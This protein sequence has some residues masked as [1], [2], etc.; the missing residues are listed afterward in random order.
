[1][2]SPVLFS[3]T[4][5]VALALAASALAFV[6]G[7]TAADPA[8]EY[9]RGV[10]AG[11]RLGR[12][13][14]RAALAEG[15]EHYER[16]FARGRAA[17]VAEGRR[18]GRAAGLRRGRALGRQDAFG[19]FPGGW[20]VDRWYVVSVTRGDDGARYGVGARVR[21]EPGQWY[22]LCDGGRARDRICQRL[23]EGAGARPSGSRRTVSR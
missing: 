3:V 2:R 18:S 4:L 20:Q 12:Q 19:S 8:G 7:R 10:A 11:E 1:V 6:G 13:E 15:E 21:V 14:A 17:G 16:I 23:R 22:G 9:E 5:I